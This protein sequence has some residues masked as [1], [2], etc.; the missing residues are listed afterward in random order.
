MK[1][2]LVEDQPMHSHSLDVLAHHLVGLCL[3]IKEEDVQI[4]K[5]LQLLTNLIHSEMSYSLI[6]ILA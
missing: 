1:N 5:V 2:R 3:E 6:L 4:S